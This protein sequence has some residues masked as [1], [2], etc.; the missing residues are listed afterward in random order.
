MRLKVKCYEF[1][2]SLG[3]SVAGNENASLDT[4]IKKHPNG[5]IK[6]RFW[7]IGL[8]PPENGLG[9]LESLNSTLRDSDPG[10]L[11]GSSQ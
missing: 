5:K 2:S 4:E 10:G 11:L 7:D 1:K 9:F 6:Q 8:K 3:L